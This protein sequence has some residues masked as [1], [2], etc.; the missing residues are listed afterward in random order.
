MNQFIGTGNLG[1]DPKLRHT[2][3]GR[4]VCNF[5]VAIDRRY[6]S[7]QGDE[8][9]IVKQTDWIPIVV[10]GVQAENCS[11]YLQKGSKVAVSGRVQPRQY[12]DG[13]GV[14][15]NTFEVVADNVEFLGRIRS[16][17]EA[18]AIS[19]DSETTPV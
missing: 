11:R 15:H 6:A 10:W 14:T 16:T 19:L 3:S 12:Q 1:G 17:E 4:A 7:G 9:R 2:S 5:N 8:R 18:Q 13:N